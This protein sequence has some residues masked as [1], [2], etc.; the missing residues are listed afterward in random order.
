MVGQQI[1][2]KWNDAAA[3]N[4][5]HENARCRGCVASQT[6][7]GEV[8]NCAPHDGGTKAAKHHKDECQ[9]NC[10]AK[11]RNRDRF[12]QKHNAE[13][14]NNAKQGGGSQHRTRRHFAAK[15][16]ATQSAYHHAEK[17]AANHSTCECWTN[18]F[19]FRKIDICRVWNADF[20]AHVEENGHCSQHKMAERKWAVFVFGNA[21]SLASG[22][23]FGRFHV[24]FWNF[25]KADNDR[26]KRKN[27]HSDNHGWSHIAYRSIFEIATNQIAQ[28][29]GGKR[30]ANRVARAAKLHQAVA[31]VTAAAQRVEHWIDYNVEQT[32][33]ESGNKCANHIDKKRLGWARNPLNGDAHQTDA[34]GQKCRKFVAAAFENEAAR[35]AHAGVSDKIGKRAEL[36]KCFR[37]TAVAK[38]LVFDN[39][40]HRTRKMRNEGN[41]KE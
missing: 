14:K 2:Q 20:Q 39:H 35:N 34:N 41:H 4:E 3:A 22:T 1:L 36:R 27:H 32:H 17:I 8:E 23:L 38:E 12:G 28:Q 16:S 33:R 18:P 29:N 19:Y 30:A 31:C 37:A 26:C 40:A 5:S 25:C 11:Q 10:F 21:P 15:Q 24:R 6:F 13:A 7:G 9:R